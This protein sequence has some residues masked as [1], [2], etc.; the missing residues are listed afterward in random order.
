MH[1]AFAQPT[2]R[3]LHPPV[4]RHATPQAVSRWPCSGDAEPI[5]TMA[6][7]TRRAR[8]EGREG[9]MGARH[10]RNALTSAATYL[11]DG[12]ELSELG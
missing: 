6:R 1:R 8:P 11:S 3:R 5:L 2:P 9:A 12:G 10:V 4:P 7:Q